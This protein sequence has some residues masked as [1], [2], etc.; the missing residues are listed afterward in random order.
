M[1]VIMLAVVILTVAFEEMM[2]GQQMGMAEIFRE[3]K[4]IMDSDMEGGFGMYVAYFVTSFLLGPFLGMTTLYGSVTMGQLFRKHRGIM[5]IVC[6]LMVT[7]ASGII[8]MIVTVPVMM[9]EVTKAEAYGT[10][11]VSVSGSANYYVTL[12]ISVIISIVMFFVAC[13]IDDKK[14]NME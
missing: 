2:S 5:A 4:Q 12:G 13:H 7:F 14:L 8:S 9:G 11:N 6:Y 3:M 1:M 10:V